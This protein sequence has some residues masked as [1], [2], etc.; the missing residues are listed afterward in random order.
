MAIEIG[1][2]YTCRVTIAIARE[3]G[4]Y[5]F[6]VPF[7]AHKCE[8][9]AFYSAPPA[10]TII[11]RYVTALSR[12]LDT[13]QSRRPPRTLYFG[14]GTPTL[15]TVEQ[16]NRILKA[17]DKLGLLG[18]AEW[19]IECNPATLSREKASILKDHGVNRVSMGVQSMDPSLLARLGRV[20]TREMVFRTYELLRDV[21][22][23]NIGI[24][25]M[26]GIPGQSLQTWQ[27]TLQEAVNLGPDHLSCYEVT[28]EEDTPLF[29][30]LEA[31]EIDVDEDLNC[32]MYE[33]LV[34]A[35]GTAGYQQYEIANFA[36]LIPGETGR[37]PLRAS[38]HNVNYWR[39]G[40]YHG[41]GPSATSYRGGIRSRN[42]A[43]T[44]LYCDLLEQGRSPIESSEELSP[45]AR[46][47]EIG[48]FGLR[49]NAGWGFEEFRSITGFDLK[50]EWNADLA[51]LCDHGFGVLDGHGFRLTRTGLRFADLAA[52]RFLR[53]EP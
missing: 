15:L 21:G 20:H 7:C 18:A 14:G 19:T 40:E 47:G 50:Q 29:A 12:E 8:Y 23:D 32:Q 25:L 22:F 1:F 11:D 26:F 3:V 16:W 52:E 5:Y 38:L 36:R 49:M 53:P 48:A 30:Q 24:D 39:G 41:L 42:W 27:S 35:S 13:F 31:G 45:L 9:C 33:E 51:W 28:Y 37:I 17:L 4:S 43:N 34:D 6:H 46:A 10:G 2:R 44:P